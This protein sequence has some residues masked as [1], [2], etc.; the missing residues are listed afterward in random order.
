MINIMIEISLYLI[1]ALGI[2]FIFGWLITKAFFQKR[3]NNR[4]KEVEVVSL[5]ASPKETSFLSEVDNIDNIKQELYHYKKE[6]KELLENNNKLKLNYEGQKYVLNE[7]NE[8]LDSFQSQVK[9][10]DEV[11]EGLTGKLLLLE[12][13]LIEMKKK[14]NSEIDAFLFER[15]DITEKYKKL[16]AKQESENYGNLVK[17][18]RWLS[19]LFPVPSKS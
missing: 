16:L 17:D 10:K 13:E 15:I 1:A 5:Y 2:G 11:I 6:N 7:H 12:G 4:E 19:K 3:L 9:N 14:H 8:T 18:E